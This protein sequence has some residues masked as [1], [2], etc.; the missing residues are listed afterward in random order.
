MWTVEVMVR[1]RVEGALREGE[2]ARLEKAIRG[3]K[4]K[5]ILKHW[6]DSVQLSVWFRS[7]FQAEEEKPE[8]RLVTAKAA[9]G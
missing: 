5:R 6:R 7:R 2:Q 9:E 3:A 4:R 8:P 1:Q